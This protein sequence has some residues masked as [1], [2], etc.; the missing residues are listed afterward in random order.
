[1]ILQMAALQLGDIENFPFLDPPDKRSIRDGVQLLQELGAFSADGTITELGRR[2]A[3][4]PL[5]PRIGR[6]I[7]QAD[8]EDA[9]KRFWCSRRRYRFPIRGT[10]SGP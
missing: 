9:S 8:A 4:L 1:M 10:P 2:L 5:D 3:R 7:L 6:M